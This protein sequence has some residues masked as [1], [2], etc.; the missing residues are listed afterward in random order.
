MGELDLYPGLAPDPTFV[1]EVEASGDDDPAIETVN[2]GSNRTGMDGV[3]FISSAVR[4]HGP[5]VK[6]YVKA[7]HSQPSFSVS[8]APEPRVLANSL[9]KPVLSRM[10]PRVIEWVALNREALIRY[11]N[12]GDAILVDDLAAFLDGLKKA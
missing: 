6:Y 11:W 12:E 3:I 10:A 2:L 8:I 9:P 5:R 7:G 4:R 1:A